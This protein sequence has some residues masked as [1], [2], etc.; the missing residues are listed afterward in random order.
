MTSFYFYTAAAVAEIGGCF[1][2]WAWLRLG[3]SVYWILPGIVS[4]VVFAILLTRIEMIFAGRTF[5]AYGSV[6]IATSLLWLW[7]IEGQHP[8]K[9]DILGAIVCV[10]GAA[11]ILFGQRQQV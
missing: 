9:W 11:I 3:K 5:A 7:I 1:A 10:A 4:L 8:D 2:F 6:Y